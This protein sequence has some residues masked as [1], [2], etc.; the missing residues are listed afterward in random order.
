MQRIVF[1][2][3]GQIAHFHADVLTS[4]GCKIVGVAA[5]EDNDRLLAFKIKY[6]I[7]KSF[8]SWN[9]MVA[10]CD[11]DAIWVVASWP[12]IDEMILDLIKTGKN[13]FVEKPVALSSEKIKK[14]IE[15][16]KEYG[17]KIQ[18]GYNRRFYKF[19]PYLRERIIKGKIRSVIVEVPETTG[20]KSD[21]LLKNLWLQNSSHVV[22]LVYHLVGKFDLVF[23][24]SQSKVTHEKDTFYSLFQAKGDSYRFQVNIISVWN[25]PSNFSIKIYMEDELIELK[26]LEVLKIYQGFEIRDPTPELPIR[27]YLPKVK[28]SQHW[29]SSEDKFKPGFYDQARY[30]LG[31]IPESGYSPSLLED[32]LYVTET[33]ESFL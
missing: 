2:G 19:I 16:Q 22:D 29:G 25:S 7:N 13:I 33:I 17:T 30:F 8:M 24:D 12:A 5:K 21:F 14:A 20:G 10:E 15:L 6:Q 26:P 3:C 23:A 28:E 27:Q 31:M 9:D 1:I 18:I 4:L 11:F 32:A